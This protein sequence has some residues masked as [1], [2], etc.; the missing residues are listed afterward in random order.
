MAEPEYVLE[1]DSANAAILP[2][3]TKRKRTNELTGDGD[4]DRPLQKKPHKVDANRSIK[5]KEQQL[6]KTKRKKL[7]KVLERKKKKASVR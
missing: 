4:A 6:S 1:H 5:M 3:S 2:A 7:I